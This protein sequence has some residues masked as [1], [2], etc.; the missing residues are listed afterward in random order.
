MSKTLGPIHYMMYE[1]IKFQDII[2]SELM[3]ANTEI[4]D[5]KIPPVSTKPLDEIIDQDNI[6]GYL[7]SK[8]DIVENRLNMALKLSKN[9]KNILFLLGQKVS[10]KETYESYEDLFR[11]LHMYLLDGMPCDQATS[12]MLGDDG[13]YIV[14]NINVHEKYNVFI[15]PKDSLDKTCGGHHDQNHD[16]DHSHHDSFEI[17][18]NFENYQMKKENSSYHEYRYEFLRGYF[19]NTKYNVEL[20]EGI[21]YKIY[22]K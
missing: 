15:D 13:L 22:E 9:P 8:I 6:H 1:K 19:S 4:I 2:T 11:H 3:E 21:N 7:A 16:H 10:K 18:E 17:K 5:K 20:I 12:A 14:T